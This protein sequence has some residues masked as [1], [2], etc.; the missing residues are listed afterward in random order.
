[1][2]DPGST[3]I[4]RATGGAP[5]EPGAGPAPFDPFLETERVLEEIGPTLV[6]EGVVLEIGFGRGEVLME[7]AR[8]APGRLFLG[9]EV[10]RKRALKGARRIARAGIRNIRVVHATAEYL[11]SRVLPGRCVSECWINFSDPWPKK[12]HHKR[13]LVRTETLRDLAR[14]MKPG[15]TLHVA[16]DHPGYA[17]WIAEAFVGVGGFENLN[18]PAPWS[19]ERPARLGTAYEEEFLAEGRSIAY[20]DYRRVEDLPAPEPR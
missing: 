16:T 11:L 6:A 17:E 14:V 1:L 7:M 12:R 8:T 19:R 15:A 18:A 20:F 3:P 5:T 13:R 4:S 10:S 2:S 9:V